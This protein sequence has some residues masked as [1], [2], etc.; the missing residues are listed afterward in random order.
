MGRKV[1]A[2][3]SFGVEVELLS[4][5]G[6]VVE[7][8]A[9]PKGEAKGAGKCQRCNDKRVNDQVKDGDRPVGKFVSD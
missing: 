8:V 4:M 9:C 2:V 5:A 3:G 6:E 7:Q 1:F